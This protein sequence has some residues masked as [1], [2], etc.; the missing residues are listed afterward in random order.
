MS[1]QYSIALPNPAL[2]RGSDPELSFSANG[3]DAFAEQLQ[4]ALRSP[5]LFERWRDRQPDPD[6]VD[7]ALGATD[8]QASVSGQQQ[9]LRINLVATTSLPGDIFKH[10][11][12]LLAGNHWELR[13]VR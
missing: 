8:P 1:V 4:D 5:A 11:M 9:D 12:R 10:R 7:P 3:A 2:A 13:N 6:Q